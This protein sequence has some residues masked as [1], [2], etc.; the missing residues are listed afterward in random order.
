MS[1]EDEVIADAGADVE[2]GQGRQRST[3]SFPYADL[4]S[5]VA[6][7]QAIHGNVGLGDCD[8]SQLAAW[9]NQSVKSSTFRVQLTAAR[10]FGLMGTDGAGKHRLTELGRMIVDPSRTR[11]ARARSFL[12]VPLFK[13]VFDN[14]NGSILPPAAA[15]A[16][17][18][19]ALGVAEKTKDRARQV[20]ERSADQAGFFGSGRDRLVM[21]G[22]TIGVRLPK[23]DADR[24]DGKDREAAGKDPLIDAL[25][26]KLPKTGDP[27]SADERVTWLQMISMAFQMTYGP[28]EAIEIKKKGE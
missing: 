25:I 28:T 17:D 5:A 18:M 22:I 10:L 20:F 19:V 27:W 16:R 6:L 24:H 12:M 13:A 15:L 14:Y 23:P 4:N 2:D 26:Q 1:S 21:P 11:E 3:I 8:D 9:T 7:A